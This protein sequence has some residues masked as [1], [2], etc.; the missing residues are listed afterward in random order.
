MVLHWQEM[1]LVYSVLESRVETDSKFHYQP[2]N[3]EIVQLREK[4][5]ID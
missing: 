2:H 3:K 4:I 5:K 1:M